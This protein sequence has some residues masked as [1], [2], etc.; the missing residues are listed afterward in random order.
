[1]QKWTTDHDF[2]NDDGNN[3]D[4]TLVG[5][6]NALPY[7]VNYLKWELSVQGGGL[8]GDQSIPS[9]MTADCL[10]LHLIQLGFFP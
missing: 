1:M 6:D 5:S 7:P 3:T 4:T 2:C 8:G 9:L 10:F